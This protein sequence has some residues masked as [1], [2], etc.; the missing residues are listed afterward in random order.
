MHTPGDELFLAVVH[1]RAAL[2]ES[3]FDIQKAR[4]E[5]LE[6]QKVLSTQIG[7]KVINFVLSKLDITPIFRIEGNGRLEGGDYIPAGNVVFRRTKD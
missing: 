7:A 4:D 5:H 2:Y 3:V 1:P 6:F